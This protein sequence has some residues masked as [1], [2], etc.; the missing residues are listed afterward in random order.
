MRLEFKASGYQLPAS[1][2]ELEAGSR[3]LEAVEGGAAMVRRTVMVIGSALVLAGVAPSAQPSLS[4]RISHTDPS[5]YRHYPRR[6]GGAPAGMN[7]MTLVE[8]KQMQTNLLYMF[9]GEMPP[10]GGIGHHY[11]TRVEEMFIIFDNEAEFT[12]DGRTSRL[13][14]PIGAPVRYDHSHAIYNP[15]DRPAQWMNIGVSAVKGVGGGRDIGDDRVG[16]PLDPRPVFVTMPLDRKLLQPVERLLGGKGVAQYR[17][18]LGPGDF[19]SNW[20]YV[21]HLVLPPGAT[22]GR[23]Q[24]EGLEEIF[25]VMQ[26]KGMAD[27]GM[28]SA[29]LEKGDALPIRIN[30]PHGI[31]NPGTADLELMVIGIALAKEKIQIDTPGGQ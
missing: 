31:G 13:A 19:F 11:H 6:H 10:K 29:P 24:H 5:K 8:G 23:H 18:A 7:V 21:D 1:R 27:V 9:R 25:Y 2:F 3:K 12:I 22:L 26:G 17:R 30:E 14:G 16:V 4:E 20:A 15:T 28:D